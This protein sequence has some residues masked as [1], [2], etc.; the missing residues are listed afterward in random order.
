MVQSPTTKAS[1]GEN[2]ILE[3]LNQQVLELCC[4][5]QIVFWIINVL[6]ARTNYETTKRETIAVAFMTEVASEFKTVKDLEFIQNVAEAKVK[7][8]PLGLSPI[9]F[10]KPPQNP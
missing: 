9:F 5:W 10:E 2:L 6:I 7:R 4:P 1:N 3:S 8:H